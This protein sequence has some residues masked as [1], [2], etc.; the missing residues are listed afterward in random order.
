[1]SNEIN[2]IVVVGGGTA[3]WLTAA[4]L[5]ADHVV[6]NA[7]NSLE[8]ELVESPN[9]PTVGVGE[10][11]WPSMRETLK[12]IGIDEGEFLNVCD[13]S[14]KQGSKFIGWQAL[15]E[16]HYYH[17]FTLPEQFHFINLAEH[18]LPYQQDI[19]F[20]PAVSYQAQIC[21]L[22]LAPKQ[23]T[24]AQYGFLA[25][26]GYHLDAGKFAELLK[27]HC[28]EKLGV[29]FIAA[30]VEAVS[31]NDHGNITYLKTACG[32]SISGDLFIDCSGAKGL[33]INQT[34]KVP[35][36][37]QKHVLFND[38]AIAAHVPYAT[39][40][41]PIS[42]AT[43]ST[44]QSNGWIWDIGLQSR[45]GVGYVYASDYETDETAEQR[46]KDYITSTSGNN[47]LSDVIEYRKLTFNPG[48][49]AKFWQNNCI[50]IGMSAGFIE[51]LEASAIA[52]IEQSAKFVS[53]Q[54]PRHEATVRIVRERFNQ[55][56]LQRWAQI[57]DFL[58]LH[59]ALSNR[60]DSDYWRD[61]RES[62]NLPLE[63]QKKLELWQYQTPY[64]Y[65]AIATEELFPPASY[66]YVYYGMG[67]KT[68]LNKNR[69]WLQTHS[70]AQHIFQN[71]NKKANQLGQALETNRALLNKI[72]Q[73]G[74][75]KI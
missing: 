36:V 53:S 11:T 51:P 55:K 69:Q 74:L 15:N 33:L 40:E 44:A 31:Q 42:S 1:M 38:R 21:E 57:I 61:N 37:S 62:K 73:F 60:D 28:V 16:Q 64:T 67:G 50:A 19:G 46:L 18:W 9:I 63:L 27:R 24:H 43:L 41:S 17:P 35:F 12:H 5:A 58:K 25:N 71:N 4:I 13:A 48:H 72:K 29:T 54:L 2:K 59:Y 34:L 32:N 45:R 10:G 23:I 22:G 52:L 56:F 75:S 70:Q 14:F 6:E 66:Q 39:A 65:D 47:E 8:V 30:E 20:A 68:I 3:G 26:Y 7:A 49:R